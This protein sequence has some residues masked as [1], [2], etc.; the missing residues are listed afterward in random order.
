MESQKKFHPPPSPY[1]SIFC[2]LALMLTIMDSSL[3]SYTRTHYGSLSLG[4]FVFVIHYG[5]LS[6]SLWGLL[7]SHKADM[8]THV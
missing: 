7:V 4:H 6:L 3:I 5:S 1:K 2:T 8:A